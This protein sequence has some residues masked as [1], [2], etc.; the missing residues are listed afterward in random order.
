MFTFQ[1]DIGGFT[2]W[3][4]LPSEEIEFFKGEKVVLRGLSNGLKHFLST[5]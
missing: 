4:G 5:D 3:T 1:E 2:G